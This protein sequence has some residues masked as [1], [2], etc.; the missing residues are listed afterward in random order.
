MLDGI[1]SF[2]E[3]YVKYIP[4]YQIAA[5][6]ID[7]ELAN[8][9][10]FICRVEASLRIFYLAPYFKRTFQKCL[11]EGHGDDADLKS[12]FYKPIDRLDQYE[13]LWGNIIKDLP[14]AHPDRHGVAR[15]V[16]LLAGIRR[17][18]EPVTRGIRQRALISSNLVFRPGDTVVSLDGVFFW[19]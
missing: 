18:V 15:V 13:R 8:N 16:D 2:Q 11:K 17:E 1:L 19:I 10:Y 12:F 5:C 7:E 3:V 14:L 9:Q 4:L 6:R